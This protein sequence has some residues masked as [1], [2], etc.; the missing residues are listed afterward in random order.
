MRGD[1]MISEQA[2]TDTSNDIIENAIAF[3]KMHNPP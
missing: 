1:Q 2:V 3:E